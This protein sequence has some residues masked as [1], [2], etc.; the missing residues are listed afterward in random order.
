MIF[1]VCCVSNSMIVIGNNLT[2]SVRIITSFV[3]NVLVLKSLKEILETVLCVG[4]EFLKGRSNHYRPI[5]S[6]KK[7]N[8]LQCIQNLIIFIT[9]KNWKKLNMSWKTH[10][11]IWRDS[12]TTKRNSTYKSI[13]F[14]IKSEN[15]PNK[16][17]PN[18]KH[19]LPKD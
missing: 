1:S 5:Y 18:R 10:K 15:W 7:S 3:S 6:Y 19:W 13:N 12:P 16:S 11:Q 14:K 9:N 8:P 17:S 2:K 4:K